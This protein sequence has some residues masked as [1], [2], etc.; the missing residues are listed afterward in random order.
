MIPGMTE[1]PVPA[2]NRPET[3]IVIRRGIRS[4][5]RAVIDLY[6]PYADKVTRLDLTA[7]PREEEIGSEVKKLRDKLERAGNRVS[8]VER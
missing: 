1:K 8:Y 7:G 5:L 2:D 3:R 4:D 6:D